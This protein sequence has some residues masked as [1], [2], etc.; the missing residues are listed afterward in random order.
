MTALV[1]R[2]R[3]ARVC[4]LFGSDH[5]GEALVAARQAEKIRQKLDLER[6]PVGRSLVGKPLKRHAFFH[7]VRPTG[8]GSKPRRGWHS[9]PCPPPTSPVWLRESAIIAL[10]SWSSPFSLVGVFPLKAIQRPLN[11]LWCPIRLTWLPTAWD[12]RPV[13]AFRP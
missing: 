10:R 6:I 9:R 12:A 8:I 3:L 11:V 13:W 5:D 4:G 2:Q 1:D 7:P